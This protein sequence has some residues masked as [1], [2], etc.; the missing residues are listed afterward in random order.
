VPKIRGRWRSHPWQDDPHPGSLV[1]FAVEIDPAAE[2][3]CHD[4]VDDVQAETGASMIAARGKERIECLAPDIE[5]HPTA[6]VGK[7]NLN[8][9]VT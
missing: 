8:I 5:I 6:I 3:I 7:K 1:E 2:A 4:G 9:L